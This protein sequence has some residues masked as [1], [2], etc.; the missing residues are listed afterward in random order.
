MPEIDAVQIQFSPQ[1]LGL[2]NLSLGFIM[3]G[4]ALQLTVD[5]F[6]QLARAPRPAFVGLASQFVVLPAL[7]FALVLLVQP[8]PSIALGMIL[9]A[10]CPGGNISNFMSLHADG[11]V[12]LSVT[13]TAVSTVAAMACTPLNLALWGGL[14]PPTASLL[15]AV[16]VSFWNVFQTVTV[17]LGGP[18]LAGM[19]VRHAAPAT[20]RRLSRVMQ[21]LSIALFAVIVGVALARNVTPLVGHLDT[22]FGLVLVHNAA[23]LAAGYGLSAAAGLPVRDRRTLAIETGIQNSGLGLILTFNFFGGLGGMALVA[24]WWGIWHI[25]SGLALSSLWRAQPVGALSSDVG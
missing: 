3:F 10:A 5:D 9:V 13:L 21:G 22:V 18:L 16:D 6:R 20:A 4:V 15:Q 1:S 17:V 11:H 19:A 7:T 23:A 12:A 14:Y 8:P 2:L 25:V 24:G